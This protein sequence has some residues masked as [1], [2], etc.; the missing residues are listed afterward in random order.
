LLTK[1]MG[2]KINYLGVERNSEKEE[3]RRK[4]GF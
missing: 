2:A 1:T 4:N 3:K